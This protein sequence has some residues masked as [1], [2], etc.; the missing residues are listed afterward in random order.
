M[1]VALLVLVATRV[2][3]GHLRVVVPRLLVHLLLQLAVKLLFALFC[4]QIDVL[5]LDELLQ[6]VDLFIVQIDA[7]LVGSRD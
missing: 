2:I 4:I 3:A 7:H 1:L 5:L 6:F